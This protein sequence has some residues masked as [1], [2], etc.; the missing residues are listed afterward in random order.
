MQGEG[1]PLGHAI[2]KFPFPSY[3]LAG[4][5]HPIDHVASNS[6]FENIFRITFRVPSGQNI[7]GWASAT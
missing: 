4:V 5:F 3:W 6:W 7:G 1:H 2:F